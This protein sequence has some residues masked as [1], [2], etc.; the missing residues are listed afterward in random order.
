M[1]IWRNTNTFQARG[2]W[3]YLQLG[4]TGFLWGNRSDG[5]PLSVEIL[6]PSC[7]FRIKMPKRR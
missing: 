4:T 1:E 2:A 3:F 5:Y 6:T 7:A